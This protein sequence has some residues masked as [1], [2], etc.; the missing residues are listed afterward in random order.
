MTTGRI[1]Q[2]AFLRDA[3]HRARVRRAGPGDE[4]RAR[5][6]FGSLNAFLHGRGRRPSHGRR[7]DRI[8]ETSRTSWASGATA[9]TVGAPGEHEGLYADL[10][11][12]VRIDGW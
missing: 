9:G 10:H 2:V 1:N 3:A 8:R 5:A 7:V 12:T 6:S 4:T 11:R